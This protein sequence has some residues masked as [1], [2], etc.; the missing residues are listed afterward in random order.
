MLW[1][2]RLSISLNSVAPSSSAI[3]KDDKDIKVSSIWFSAKGNKTT[4]DGGDY[5]DT[6]VRVTGYQAGYDFR[7]SD[8][9]YLGVYLGTASGYAQTEGSYSK[10]VDIKHSLNY[11]IYGTHSFH[12]GRYLDYIVHGGKFDSKMA[13]CD[14]WGTKSF[15][16]VISYGR[17]FRMSD[18]LTL[19]PYL[20]FKYD[21]ITMDDKTIAGNTVTTDDEN[22]LSMKLGL[23]AYTDAGFYGGIAYSRG[24][25]GDLTS[26]VNTIA[27]PSSDFDENVFYLNA[28]YKGRLNKDTM[29]NVNFEKMYGDY[30]GWTAEGR[31]DFRF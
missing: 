17:K 24:L 5:A 30:H 12:G 14:M 10:R 4:V 27:L 7:L 18:T 11:G 3:D 23:N 13:G 28:G 2:K 1:A 22:A 6:R 8:A 16:G 21:H 31:I 29:L 20:R 26:Y 25:A 9:D 19:D 15:G